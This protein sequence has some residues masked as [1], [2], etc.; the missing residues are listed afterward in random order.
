MTNNVIILKNMDDINIILKFSKSDQKIYSLN[1]DVHKYLQKFNV[2]H[3]IG[4]ELL[5]EEDLTQIFDKTV[6]LYD[7]YNYLPNN[8]KLIF[9]NTNILHFLDTGEFHQFVI[10]KL[11]ELCIVSKIIQLENPQN[12]IS[13]SSII[14][15][16]KNF[17]NSDH[18]VFEE[19]K[20]QYLDDLTWNKIDIKFN[21]NTIPISFT[22]S[23][24]FYDRLKSIFENLLCGFN[25]LWAEINSDKEIILFLEINPSQYRDLILEIS[26]KNKQIV[27]LNNRRSSVWNSSSINLL[28]MTKSK[29]INFEKLLSKSEKSSLSILR[30]KYMKILKEIFSDPKTSEIFTF[31][32]ISFWNQLED[33]IF[34]SIQN[35]M[36]FYLETVFGI[37]NFLDNSKIKCVL[38]LNVVG[39][40][41]KIVLSQ[42]NKQIPSI[43]LEHAFANY[44]EKIS[45]YDIQSMYSLFFDK[46]A[47]WGNVQ[48]NYIQKIHNISNDR[49]IVCGSPR[50]D[51]FFHSQSKK[52]Q[53]EKK[54]ILLCPRPIIDSSGHKST[55]LYEHYELYLKNFLKQISSIKNIKLIVKLHPG[56]DPHNKELKRIIHQYDQKISI[57]HIHSIQN[58]IEQSDLVITISPE[59]YDPSTVILESI[60]LQKPIINVVLDDKFYNFSYEKDKAVVSLN[61]DQNL[62]EMI[63][64]ILNDTEF[65]KSIL[66]NGENFLH[67]YLSNHGNAS[68]YLANYIMNLK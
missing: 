1:N 17:P 65:K 27:F 46:I 6:S 3:S 4:E 49:I 68:Q 37:K 13:N 47:V 29:V 30:S 35:R 52:S 67:S 20:D 2:V 60:I 26:K 25:H 53:N 5:T 21:V 11:Y 39:E 61:K 57:F 54:S 38:S 24:T 66:Q 14:S 51:L 23:K 10:Q 41:E 55:K 59:G 12:I 8:E 56:N 32:G 22:I 44:T 63:K 31:N 42:L 34:L 16:I 7:W 48:K 36:N 64:K 28:K 58:L 15:L 18:F 9:E 43:M 62:L 19:I 45:R 40:T 50:H 33:K